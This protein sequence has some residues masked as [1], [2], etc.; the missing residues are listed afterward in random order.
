[1]YLLSNASLCL[2]AVGAIDFAT[3][4]TWG[5]SLLSREN[6]PGKE[7][8]PRAPHPLITSSPAGNRVCCPTPSSLQLL[9]SEREEF[10]ELHGILCAQQPLI[11]SPCLISLVGW[12]EP[13]SCPAPNIWASDGSLGKRVAKWKFLHYLS[14]SRFTY[15]HMDFDRC[16]SLADFFLPIWI[17]VVPCFLCSARAETVLPISPLRGLSLFGIRLLVASQTHLSRGST[18]VMIL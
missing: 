1:M 4:E 15:P 12:R 8:G 10:R 6:C 5:F 17:V 9:I 18:K 11:A 13:V 16:Y 14:C 3:L 7:K 2:S